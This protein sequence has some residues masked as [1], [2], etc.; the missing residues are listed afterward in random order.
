MSQPLDPVMQAR[1]DKL[2]DEMSAFID[3]YSQGVPWSVYIAMLAALNGSVDRLLTE[4]T[5]DNII[6]LT[7][8]VAGPSTD[9]KD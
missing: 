6:P 2:R 7:A 8:I 9:R 5:H 3:T 1:V 4:A